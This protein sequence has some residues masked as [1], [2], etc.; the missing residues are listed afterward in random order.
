MSNDESRGHREIL[1]VF[2]VISGW[3]FG[4]ESISHTHCGWVFGH[5]GQRYFGVKA[6]V[7]PAFKNM[8]YTHF[9]VAKQREGLAAGYHSDDMSH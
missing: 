4:I 2:A 6:G 5:L 3:G 8:D 1:L 7:G 9:G